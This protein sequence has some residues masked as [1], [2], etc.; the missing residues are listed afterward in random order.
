MVNW[1]AYNESLVRRGQVMLDFDVIDGWEEEL[2]KMNEGKVGEPYHYPES[3]VQL[4]GYM[5]T[6][7]RL[8]YRQTEGVVQAHA[9]KKVPSIPLITVQ[10]AGVLT[11]SI[12]KS[13]KK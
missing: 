9:G 6:Y 4:L 12:L 7:F 13:M 5:R 2:E 11:S 3:F 8:P 1:R 10:L